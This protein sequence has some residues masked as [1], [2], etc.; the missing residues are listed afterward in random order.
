MGDRL[1]QNCNLGSCAYSE[2]LSFGRTLVMMMMMMNRLEMF[3]QV[4]QTQVKHDMYLASR[5]SVRTVTSQHIQITRRMKVLHVRRFITNITHS[6]RYRSSFVIS[7]LTKLVKL[8]LLICP[9]QD[10][11]DLTVSRLVT[12]YSSQYSSENGEI[13]MW[14]K[15]LT[16]LCRQ[17]MRGRNFF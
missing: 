16:G 12:E 10:Q 17:I 3:V 7:F 4:L 2:V 9:E 8:A 5:H 15:Y 1:R 14:P 13:D 6:F 11:K